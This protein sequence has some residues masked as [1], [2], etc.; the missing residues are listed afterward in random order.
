MILYAFEETCHRPKVY[1]KD[2]L[3]QKMP[4]QTCSMNYLSWKI[5]KNINQPMISKKIHPTP[6]TKEELKRMV[7]MTENKEGKPMT[8]VHIT[9]IYMVWQAIALLS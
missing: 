3:F 8:K 1:T 2:H 4:L 6:A 5:Q 9:Q 7:Q